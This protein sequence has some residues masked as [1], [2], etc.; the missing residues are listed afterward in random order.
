M[1]IHARNGVVSP[2][3]VEV[4][5]S[6]ADITGK[7]AAEAKAKAA[8]AAMAADAARAEAEAAEKAVEE[9]RLKAARD[10][11]IKGMPAYFKEA[12]AWRLAAKE[13]AAG[14]KMDAAKA[15]W[16][17]A[18]DAFRGYESVEAAIRPAVYRAAL[19]TA[20]AIGKDGIPAWFLNDDKFWELLG[21]NYGQLPSH[22]DE[23]KLPREPEYR[24]YAEVAGR[25]SAA[26]ELLGRDYDPL[27]EQ[28]M[29]RDHWGDLVKKK[30]PWAELT[31]EEREAWPL[32]KAKIKLHRK[33]WNVLEDE[34][35]AAVG[36]AVEAVEA[37]MERLREAMMNA[38]EI[39]RIYGDWNSW[40]NYSS[41]TYDKERVY[42]ADI[43]SILVP[44]VA[45]ADEIVRQIR[46]S[47]RILNGL[48]IFFGVEAT[49]VMLSGERNSLFPSIYMSG[50]DSDSLHASLDCLGV[51]GSKSSMDFATLRA[52]HDILRRLK[53]M[54]DG[55]EA[56]SGGSGKF[57]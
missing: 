51:N 25:I 52:F 48:D 46:S 47:L 11:A 24:K 14:E 12:R 26:T 6:E 21:Y 7:R 8:E 57:R 22:I 40:S 27:A 50:P 43:R 33:A 53:E 49:K 16:E 18:V 2:G 29:V 13:R 41:S 30:N 3:G 42:A 36:A 19:A 28:V 4:D 5:P 35:S 56:V 44:T 55:L 45:D 37:E 31:R 1:D 39:R 9:A 32:V 23:D 34:T 38:Y 20:S 17:K 15:A 54:A 10:A